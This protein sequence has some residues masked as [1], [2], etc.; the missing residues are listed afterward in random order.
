MTDFSILFCRPG[1]G[2][3]LVAH[4]PYHP[5]GEPLRDPRPFE[6]LGDRIDSPFF[7]AD[8]AFLASGGWVVVEIND[9][10]VSGLPEDLHPRELYEALAL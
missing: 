1:A 10:G 8:V 5:I 6:V 7:T 9:G 4:A 2:S 3:E